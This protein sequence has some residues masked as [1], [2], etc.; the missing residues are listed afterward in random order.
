MHAKGGSP[1]QGSAEREG[2]QSNR[3]RK[4][5]CRYRAC[6]GK[7]SFKAG[8]HTFSTDGWGDRTKT[9]GLPTV[10]NPETLPNYPQ[11]QLNYA[12]Q[13]RAQY[14][15]CPTVL[16]LLGFA[17]ALSHFF[18]NII[19]EM[20]RAVPSSSSRS[21]GACPCLFILYNLYRILTHLTLG[22]LKEKQRHF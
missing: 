16:H 4:S 5:R 10:S 11:C 2:E 9:H 17:V 1:W 15:S 12:S 3:F 13:Y 14:W 21:Q 20:W 18:L 8:T 7:P 19:E 6:L 22:S